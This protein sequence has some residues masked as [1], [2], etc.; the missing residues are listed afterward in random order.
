MVVVVVVVD[1]VGCLWL[2]LMSLASIVSRSSDAYLLCCYNRILVIG[3]KKKKYHDQ[4]L[5]NDGND[6]ECMHDVDM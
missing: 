5:S 6:D 4:A 1:F 2:T 3:K